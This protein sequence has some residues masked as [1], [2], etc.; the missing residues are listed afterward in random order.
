[1]PNV[2]QIFYNYHFMKALIVAATLTC[3][4]FSVSA[5]TFNWSKGFTN[6]TAWG[7]NVEVTSIKTDAAGNTYVTGWFNRTADLDPSSGVANLTSTAMSGD[8]F[9]AK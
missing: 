4:L 7:G 5:Q 1:M 8:V 6:S 2:F 3:C 9:F